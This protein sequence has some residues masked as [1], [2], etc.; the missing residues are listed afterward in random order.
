MPSGSDEAQATAER[1]RTLALLES[2]HTFPGPFGFRIVVRP[3]VRPE[4]VTAV[5]ALVGPG[6][7]TEL[8]ERPSRNGTYLAVRLRAAMDSAEQ[9][10]DVYDMLKR[11]DGVLAVL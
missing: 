10:L 2:Q 7:I 1:A 4:V 5:G 6:G 3:S 11:I 9:V 8:S